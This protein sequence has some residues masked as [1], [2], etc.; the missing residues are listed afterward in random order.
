MIIQINIHQATFGHSIIS[1]PKR[2]KK[3]INSLVQG[4]SPLKQHPLI[5]QIGVRTK[6]VA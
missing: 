2:H 1:Q 3:I 5:H 4:A 6:F